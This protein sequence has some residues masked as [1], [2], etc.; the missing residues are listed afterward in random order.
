MRKTSLRFA[1]AAVALAVVGTACGG[2]GNGGGNG[3]ATPAAAPTASATTGAA[4]LR[5]GLTGLLTEHVYLAALATG[6][7]LRGDNAGFEAFANALNGPSNSNT[8]DLVAAIG[9]AYGADVGRAFEGLWR[10]E[11][12]I[13]AVVAYTQAVAANNR[14]GAD[15]AVNDLLAYAKTFGT[16]LNSVNSNL[17]AAAVEEGVKMHATTLKTVIDAQKA[18]DQAKVYSSLREAYGHMAEFAAVLAGATVAKFPE[19]FDGAA[20][21]QASTLR[22]GMTSLL[23]EHVFLAASATGAALGGRQPQFEAAAAALN[24]PSASNTADIVAAIGSVYGADVGRAF[25]GLWR[26]EGH[27]P[28]VV[29]YTQAVAA[30]NRAGADKAVNDLLAYA[31]TFGTTLNSVNA[32]LPA[33]AVEEAIKMHATTLKAVID[34]QAAKDAARTATSL[35][36]AVGHMSETA[37]VL[38]DATVKKFPERF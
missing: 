16:T 12:H 25:D 18:G 1:A 15:K 4:T 9:S 33:A 19:K 34:A 21:S 13:P 36:T 31:K 26:S 37:T 38:A 32:N 6:A 28:A 20:D 3:S 22:A 23:R 10:S 30:N 11:G 14:A 24:G 35:R 2:N 17:P 7:A 27:I 8:S 5:A 29:A